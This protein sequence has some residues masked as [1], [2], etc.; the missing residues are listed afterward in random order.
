ML[1]GDIQHET[2]GFGRILR[3][4][5][6]DAAGLHISFELHEQLIE[7]GDRILLDLVGSLAPVLKIRNRRSH[8]RVVL[9]RIIANLGQVHESWRR[10]VQALVFGFQERGPVQVTRMFGHDGSSFW[11][12]VR[13]RNAR[14]EDLGKVHDADVPRG[15]VAL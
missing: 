6:L 3:E 9:A 7:I 1:P 15:R 5:D 13:C 4:E 14:V 8:G 2:V 10:L 11:L 12:S